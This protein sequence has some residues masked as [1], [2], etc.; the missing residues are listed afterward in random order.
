MSKGSYVKFPNIGDLK[1]AIIQKHGKKPWTVENLDHFNH[2]KKYVGSVFGSHKLIGLPNNAFMF[3][4]LE[5]EVRSSIGQPG[6]EIRS[7]NNRNLTVDIN[8]KPIDPANQYTYVLWNGSSDYI[9][10]GRSQ[11][12][13]RRLK[14]HQTTAPD[15][16]LLHLFEGD[17]EQYFQ[18]NLKDDQ[19]K[20]RKEHYYLNKNFISAIQSLDDIKKRAS[21]VTGK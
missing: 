4:E 15:M 3:E 2:I 16:F 19:Y 10:I 7:I 11:D 12:P 6:I 8:I 5:P 20:N 21:K 17:H 18:K 14:D 9:K 1:N 13:F